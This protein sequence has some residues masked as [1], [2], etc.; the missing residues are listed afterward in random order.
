MP[1]ERDEQGV[2][3]GGRRRRLLAFGL[4]ASVLAASAPSAHASAQPMIEPGR[5]ALS[6]QAS[7]ATPDPAAMRRVIVDAA[8]RHGW[9]RTLE[10]PGK[11]TLHVATGTHNATIDV[12]YDGTGFQIKYR[13]SAD[14]DYVVEDGRTLIHP[15][16]NRWISELSNEIRRSARDAVPQ[17]RRR[18]IDPDAEAPVAS[19]ASSVVR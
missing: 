2:R 17:R 6:V 7:G 5:I 16:Y 18:G 4:A 9:E 12:W 13:D 1:T 19:A 11:L 10:E 15:R 3:G 8:A 14:L